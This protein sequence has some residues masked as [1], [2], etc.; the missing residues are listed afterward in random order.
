MFWGTT[1]RT[2]PSL[3]SKANLYPQKM[4]GVNSAVEALQ[5]GCS[6]DFIATSSRQ[7]QR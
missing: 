5:N 4:I 6:D 3:R 1:S 7:L 2:L